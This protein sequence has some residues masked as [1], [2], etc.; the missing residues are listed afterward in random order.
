MFQSNPVCSASLVFAD[1]D[2]EEQIV[3]DGLIEAVNNI[4]FTSEQLMLNRRYNITIL[5]TNSN[6]SNTS[7]T[8]ISKNFI[9]IDDACPDLMWKHYRYTR[10]S[11]G[12]NFRDS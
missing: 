10:C 3:V 6:G 4:S 1:L 11:N 7:Y 12:S 5:A 2:T 9:E 8:K